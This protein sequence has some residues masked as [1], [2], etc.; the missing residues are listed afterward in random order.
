MQVQSLGTFPGTVQCTGTDVPNMCHQQA[1]GA[2]HY[3]HSQVHTWSSTWSWHCRMHVMGPLTTW[4][5]P[6]DSSCQPRLCVSAQAET[7]T[8]V[9]T[10][11]TLMALDL[12]T[13]EMSFYV[14]A[15]VLCKEGTVDRPCCP[16][17]LDTSVHCPLPT[18]SEL[19]EPRHVIL[20]ASP[21]LLFPT[22][23]REWAGQG[24]M[25]SG[26][27]G[28]LINPGQVHLC[29]CILPYPAVKLLGRRCFHVC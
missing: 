17:G 24:T 19:P 18:S 27:P 14:S 28:S 8:P 12:I 5:Q 26:K 4:G 10:P 22:Q 25:H 13:W 7:R 15:G 21:F 20:A 16:R 29:V 1:S 11:Q 9:L 6:R 23:A 3:D 2:Q